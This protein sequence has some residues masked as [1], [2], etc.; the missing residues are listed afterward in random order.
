MN[1]TLRSAF[2]GCCSFVFVVLFLRFHLRV[3]EGWGPRARMEGVP[4]QGSWWPAGAWRFPCSGRV[5][6]GRE[7]GSS[8]SSLAAKPIHQFHAS[9]LLF[10]S[11]T[12]KN[13]LSPLLPG[14][15]LSPPSTRGFQHRIELLS[16][17]PRREAF[18]SSRL[19]SACR[20]GFSAPHPCSQGTSSG[21]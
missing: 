6:L 17:K 10:S 3:G 12:C 16:P 8:G 1:E 7:V 2:S 21:H 9:S 18:P 20:E 4:G 11:L 19:S 15:P 13:V 5:G 14:L